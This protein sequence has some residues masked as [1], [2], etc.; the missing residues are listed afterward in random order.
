MKE[1]DLEKYRKAWKS[2]QSFEKS[3]LTEAG[4][5]AFLKMRSKDINRLFRG[6]LLT[7]VILKSIIGISFVVL[8]F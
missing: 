8:P 5:Q 2:E 4:I 1:I 7:D 6:S 3:P